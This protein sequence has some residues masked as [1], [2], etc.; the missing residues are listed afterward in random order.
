M[1]T[2]AFD[3]GE[4]L[5]DETRLWA[6]HADRIGVPAFTFF[7]V[8]GALIEQGRPHR[9][10]FSHF[11]VDPESYLASVEES[12][13][14]EDGLQ[15]SDL[16]P[17]VS[18]VLRALVGEGHRVGLAANQPE[19]AAAELE[20]MGLPVSFLATSAGWG[21]SKPDPEFFLRLVY[22]AGAAPG[23]ITYVGDRLDF[24]VIPANEA[25]MTSVLI[26][27]GPWGV[28]HAARPEAAAADR[29]IDSLE[30]LLA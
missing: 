24:D 9:E 6:R 25:G 2:F 15:R 18:P 19:R 10:V 11:G 28:V 8:F 14:P 27:R 13:D 3:V 16:Y 22:E 30:E 21:I 29:V 23:S 17:D 20:A 1:G 5:I 26:R 4:T 7:G 12:D